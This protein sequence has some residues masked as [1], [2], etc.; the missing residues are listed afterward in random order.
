MPDLFK[1]IGGN[2]A[3]TD[4]RAQLT[5]RGKMNDIYEQMKGIGTKLFGQGQSNLT[6]GAEDTGKASDYYAS[7]LSG[8]PA[9]VMKAASPAVNAV[10]READAQKRQNAEFGNRTGG[11][12]EA[13]QNLAATTRGQVGDVISKARSG[14]AAGLER[15]GSE[16][17]GVGTTETGQ[18][19]SAT[20]GAG[21]LASTITSEAGD[22]RAL[23]K[24]IHDAS[25][26]QW[27]Q[28]ISEILLGTGL[29]K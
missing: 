8:N 26:D 13:D 19:L 18:G 25:V 16:K 2:A 24:K 27:A 1:V 15:T 21:S 10:T 11:K 12:I 5:G 28:A 3:S 29:A 7:V 14:A 17:S 20:S 4:R 23:S 9:A 22:S 6:A